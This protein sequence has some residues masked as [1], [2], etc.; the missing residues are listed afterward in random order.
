MPN[1]IT[2]DKDKLSKLLTVLLE[3][4]IVL[5]ALESGGV[6]N[7]DWYEDAL[8][9]NDVEEQTEDDALQASVENAITDLLPVDRAA[10]IESL[11]T[12]TEAKS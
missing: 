2:V 12:F 7:W 8:E 9:R 6:D 5:E 3:S 11:S 4:Q 10:I 1:L